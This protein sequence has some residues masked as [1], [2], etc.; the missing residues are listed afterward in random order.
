MMSSSTDSFGLSR[1]NPLRLTVCLTP[2]EHMCVKYRH[3]VKPELLLQTV[4]SSYVS[5]GTGMEATASFGSYFLSL[6][7]LSLSIASLPFLAH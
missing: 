3:R 4:V 7:S 1:V 5:P 2:F 6:L